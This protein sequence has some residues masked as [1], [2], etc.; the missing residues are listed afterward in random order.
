[1]T[2]PTPNGEPNT[3]A[4][5]VPEALALEQLA[6]ALVQREATA[7]TREAELEQRE[8][9][10]QLQE[11]AVLSKD[12]LNADTASLLR[13]ANENLVV[14]TVHAQ[15][16]TEAAETATAQMSYM[17][18]HDI[19]TGLPNR[20]LLTDRLAQ[21]MALAQRHGQKVV[22]LYLD[23]D[24]FKRINDSLGHTVGDELLQAVAKRL[25]ASVRQSD[26][27]C[28]QGG[29]EFVLLLAEVETVKDAARAAAMLIEATSLPYLVGGHRLHVSASIGL[30]IFPDDG[31]DVETLLRNAD[32]AM[33]YAKK[34][35]RSNFQMFS[36]DMHARAVARQSTEATLRH[37]L[38]TGGL[39]LH[40]QPTVHLASG[41]ITGAEALVRLQQP[42][43]PL[44]DPSHFVSVAEECGLI[45][46]I[47][48]WVMREACSQAVKWLQAGLPF[49][50]MA[51]NV[52]PAEFHS[53][54]F[55]SGIRAVLQDTGMNPSCLELE[56]TESSLM[57]DNEPTVLVLRALKDMG[58]QIAIDDFGTGYS[59]L[60]Y[61]RRFPIDTL[62][63][64]QSFVH[65]IAFGNG[66]AKL[67]NAIIAMG[68]TMDLRVVAEGIETPEQ[69]IYLQAQ[70]CA[71]GQG[72]YFG[73]PMAAD[74]Y[75]DLLRDQDV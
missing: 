26:S 19:L 35:G 60:G 7:T 30:S 52:S 70:G 34:N 15:T 1:M 17:A 63:I 57:Q 11:A 75:A 56:L 36:P 37:A 38:E 29:D 23:L 43:Q 72:Y 51:V 28:R 6:H 20:A 68:L 31:S 50:H 4:D 12:G 21:S 54:D 13:E 62:K 71:E 61:L 18:Q 24:N 45:V 39:V 53:K 66:D 42:G 48:K 46:P 33:Y 67:V 58:V 8:K 22:L 14:A 25:N 27:V 64:D 32:T 47:G 40:Y 74:M 5:G 9:A 3:A 55:L 49:G 44:M 69:R 73:R 2:S 10:V 41:T 59:S 16:M 65:D